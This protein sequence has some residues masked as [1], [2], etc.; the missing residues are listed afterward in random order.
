MGLCDQFGRAISSSNTLYRTP[1]QSTP[2]FRPI[3]KPRGKTYEALSAW[4]RREMVD[5]SRV[6]AAGVPNMDTALVQAGEFSIGDSWHIKSRSSNATWGKRRDEWFNQFYAR[7]CNARGRQSDWRSSLRQLNW[8]RKVEGDYG[9]WFDGQPRKDP[10]TGKVT[11]PTGKFN[12]VKF[13]RISTGIIGGWQSVGVVSV[14]NGLDECLELPR[15]WNYYSTVTAFGSWPGIYIINDPSSPFD[16]QRIIDGI[17]VDA[18]MATLG[19]RV[20]GFNRMGLP[21]YADVPRHLLHFNFSARKQVDLVRGIPELAEAIIPTMHLDDIQHLVSMAVKL[22][23]AMAITRKSTDGNPARSGR[24]SYEVDES[25]PAGNAVKTKRAVEEIFPGIIELSSNNKEEMGVLNFNRPSMNEEEFV[26]RVET[27]LLHKLW[28]RSLIYSADSARAGTRV[29]AVQA[30]TII[31]WDQC[32]V[33]RDARFIADR[34]TEFSM[35]MG[36]IPMNDN[37]YDPY[38]YVFTVPGKF[39]VDEGNDS[40]MRLS[41]LG[42]CCISHG[43]ICEMDGYLHEE[44]REEREEEIDWILT[45]GER[46]AEKHPAFDVKEIVLMFDNGGSQLSFT[47]N[48][49]VDEDE[50]AG[51][52]TANGDKVKTKEGVA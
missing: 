17:I 7:D 27:S 23:S 15:T 46:L 41:A 1:S 51:A 9:L 29:V 16:G 11:D 26:K 18:N 33:E 31:A 37:L 6:I 22:A 12:V 4:Q 30:N 47:D 20:V 25:D 43:M 28:P 34:A 3:A 14:G 52:K 36:W 13:D 10:M 50:E 19:Y 38:D 49:Q 8:T 35:R 44:I 39:T 5:V 24:Q 21:T 45:A 48:A 32:C 2:D 40:K 42:R